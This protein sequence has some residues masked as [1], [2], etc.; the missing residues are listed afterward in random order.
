MI[1][2]KRRKCMAGDGDLGLKGQTIR[3]LGLGAQGDIH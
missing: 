3:V 2:S 1:W